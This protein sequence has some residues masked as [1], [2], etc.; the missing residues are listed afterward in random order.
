[1]TQPQAHKTVVGVFRNRWSAD[2]CFSALMRRGY[3]SSDINIMMSDQTRSREYP[4]EDD[5]P[6]F[7]V[8]SAPIDV[9]ETSGVAAPVRVEPRIHGTSAGNMAAEGVG[10]GGSIGTMVGATLAAIA[11]V[12]TALVIPGLNLIVA[13]PVLAALAGGG[14]GAVTGGLVGGM[15]GL[16]IPKQDAEVYNKALLEGG[17]VMGVRTEAGDADDIHEL[18][19][20]HA[21]EQV[22]ISHG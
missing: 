19:I 8:A 2:D 3:L 6:P 12:G 9:D 11:A 5:D 21:G 18:M 16:G 15:V 1:M 22:T 20:A 13:G 10:V 17:V 14:A 7:S 4:W